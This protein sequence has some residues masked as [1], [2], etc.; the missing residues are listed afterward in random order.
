MLVYKLALS[1]YGITRTMRIYTRLDPSRRLWSTSEFQ[2]M[3]RFLM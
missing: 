1:T 3:R 2:I